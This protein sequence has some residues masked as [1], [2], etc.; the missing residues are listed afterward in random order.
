MEIKNSEERLFEGYA[1]VQ[2]K[3]KQGD[4][5]PIDQVL[6]VLPYY[7]DLGGAIT[8]EHTDKVVGK[9][10]MAIKTTVNNIPAIKIVGKIS[11]SLPSATRTWDKI[12][13]GIYKGLSISG[14]IENQKL[15]DLLSIAVCEKGANPMATIEVVSVAKAEAPTTS[16]DNKYLNADGSFK[17]GFDGCVDAMMHRPNKPLQEEN[18]K[19][20]CAYIG[21]QTGNIGK[22]GIDSLANYEVDNMNNKE[23]RKQEVVAPPKKEEVVTPPKKETVEPEQK[24]QTGPTLQEVLSAVMELKSD[25][26]EI[27]AKLENKPEE[28]EPQTEEVQPVQQSAKVDKEELKKEIVAEVK[29]SL[30]TSDTPRV[31]VAKE[32]KKESYNY[33]DILSGNIKL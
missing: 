5:I 27:K 26:A 4:L 29:K 20:L 15:T 33:K 1:S 23:V 19:K 3:D 7:M 25:V 8:D 14:Y 21:R 16:W 6:D 10:L 22:S 30:K 28:T 2:I 18:A 13:K 31:E 12:K 11:K 32:D 24:Q 9:T 17:N